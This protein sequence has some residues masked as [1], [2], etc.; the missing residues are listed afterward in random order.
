VG[1]EV[2]CADSEVAQLVV[3]EGED[4]GGPGGAEAAAR[5]AGGRLKAVRL[6]RDPLRAVGEHVEPGRRELRADPHGAERNPLETV[7]E[8]VAMLLG[9]RAPQLGKRSSPIP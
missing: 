4:A 5:E 1:L 8:E 9:V 7:A 2:R 6:D 3:R